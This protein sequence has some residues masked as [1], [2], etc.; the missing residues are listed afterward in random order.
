MNI[1]ITGSSG[2]IGGSFLQT[3]ADKYTFRTFSL[4]NDDLDTLPLETIDTVVHCAAIVHKRENIPYRRYKEINIDYPVSL[5]KKAKKSGA[6]HFVFL[7]SVAIYGETYT[8]VDENTPPSP[9]TPYAK[10]K[11]EAERQ[12]L[13]LSDEHFIVSIVRPPMVY[14]QNAPGNID[15]LVKLVKRL[16]VFPFRNADNARS[17]VYIGN[18]LSLI[19]RIVQSRQQGLFLACDDEAV[20]TA[21]LISAIAD[22]LGKKIYLISVPFFKP[23]LKK[24]KPSLY[25]KLYADLKIDNT[26]TK[27]TLQF[28]TPYTFE[29]GI[30]RT[31]KGER[32]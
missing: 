4:Q 27:K 28:R 5:A 6:K 15:R 23:L 24:L 32:F 7:S 3:Y 9:A 26:L 18:L 14:G 2:Y 17:F 31:V 19:D 16:N 25:N 1:L 8:I 22:A 10:S 29:E 11:L 20:S 30:A 12:L 13:T 21:K